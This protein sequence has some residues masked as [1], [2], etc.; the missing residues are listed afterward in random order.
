MIKPI[1][2]RTVNKH[3]ITN[4]M[5]HVHD[6]EIG[7]VCQ[8]ADQVKAEGK[9]VAWHIHF[10]DRHSK[11]DI[12]EAIKGKYLSEKEA[13]EVWDNIEIFEDMAQLARLIMEDKLEGEQ[14]ISLISESCN[15]LHVYSEA[16]MTYVSEPKEV[17]IKL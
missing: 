14:I 1:E 12:A 2:G 11:K 5:G 10:D 8:L 16:N 13:D 6:V 17:T 3:Y 9:R 7:I 15:P 4:K